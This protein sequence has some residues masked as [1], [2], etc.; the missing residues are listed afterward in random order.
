LLSELIPFYEKKGMKALYLTEE[1]AMAFDKAI[2]QV[3]DWWVNRVG[4]DVGM[5]ALKHANR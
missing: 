1:E 2:K 3:I 5:T 4:E